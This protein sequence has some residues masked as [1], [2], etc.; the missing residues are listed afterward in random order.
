[1]PRSNQSIYC[2]HNYSTSRVSDDSWLPISLLVV[3][4]WPEAAGPTRVVSIII[5]MY[6]SHRRK[7]CMCRCSDAHTM[8]KLFFPFSK[9]TYDPVK[10]ETFPKNSQSLLKAAQRFLISRVIMALITLALA[11]QT[12]E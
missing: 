8:H 12:P 3:C 5:P 4:T 1:M 10:F 2:R 11:G 6:E 7:V 9:T